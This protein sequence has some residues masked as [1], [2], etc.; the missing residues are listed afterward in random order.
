MSLWSDGCLAPW[1]EI[2]PEQDPLEHGT[3]ARG[4][5]CP[6]LLLILENRPSRAG[7]NCS[8]SFE[9]S[10]ISFLSSCAATRNLHLGYSLA[11]HPFFQG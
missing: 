7:W 9:L 6:V 3:Q 2:W 8:L 4:H 5:D 1:A 11:W 10:L